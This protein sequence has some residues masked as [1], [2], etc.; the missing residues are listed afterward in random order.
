MA[1]GDT[2]PLVVVGDIR[3]RTQWRPIS[4]RLWQSQQQPGP[5]FFFFNISHLIWCCVEYHRESLTFCDVSLSPFLPWFFSRPQLFFPPHHR[6]TRA[7][8][9][10]V[11]QKRTDGRNK[12]SFSNYKRQ[13]FLVDCCVRFPLPALSLHLSSVDWLQK[14]WISMMMMMVEV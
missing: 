3:R 6:V 9:S 12:K 14:Y 1:H 8:F 10:S 2:D 7:F 4:K 13:H 5:V 11:K